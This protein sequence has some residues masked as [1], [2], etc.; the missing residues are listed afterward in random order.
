MYILPEKICVLAVDDDQEII[1]IISHYLTEDTRFS[2]IGATSVAQALEILVKEPISA[3]I[4]DYQMPGTDGIEFLSYLRDQGNDLP[5]ILFTGRGCEEVVI[6]ALNHGANFYLMKGEQPALQFQM[7]KKQLIEIIAKREADKAL[8]RSVSKNRRM[9]A[10]LRATLEAT[11]DG[12]LVAGEDGI[13]TDYNDRFVQIWNIPESDRENLTINRFI[14]FLSSQVKDNPLALF[15]PVDA[16][17]TIFSSSHYSLTTLDERII[18]LYIHPQ[19]CDSKAIGRVFSF[20]DITSRVKTERLLHESRERFRN[21]FEFSPIS[22]QVLDTD[23]IIREVNLAWLKMMHLSRE[24]VLGTPFINLIEPTLRERFVACIEDILQNGKKHCVELT[25]LDGEGRQVLVLADGNVIRDNQGRIRQIQ[26]ILRDITYQKKTEKQLKW[27]ESLLTEIVGMLPFGICVTQGNGYDIQYQNSRFADLWG[28]DTVSE[29]S[30]ERDTISL[31]DFFNVS[32]YQFLTLSQYWDRDA[33]VGSEIS[34]SDIELHDRKIIRAFKRRIGED[35]HE[36]QTLWA[37]EDVTRFRMQEEEIRRYARKIEIFSRVISIS[38][39]AKDLT[40]L[41]KYALSAL[42]SLLNVDGGGLYIKK[43]EKQEF[44]LFCHTGGKTGFFESKT[45]IDDSNEIFFKEPGRP[46]LVRRYHEVDPDGAERCDISSAAFIPIMHEDRVIGTIFLIGSNG[47]GIGE[48]DPETLL[49]IGREIGSAMIRLLDHERILEER[50]NFENLVNTIADM[51][52]VIDAVHG[53]ILAINTE[54]TRRTGLYAE[55]VIGRKLIERSSDDSTGTYQELVGEK[56]IYTHNF[57]GLSEE[58]IPVE[59][60]MTAGI[61]NG[62]EV[63]FCVS[64]DIREEKRASEEL[65]MREE[66]LVAIV[67][68]SPIGIA[69]FDGNDELIKVNPAAL[70]LIGVSGPEDVRHYSFSKDPHIPEEVKSLF[71]ARKPF[72]HEF[73]YNLSK[74]YDQKVFPTTRTGE[75]IIR[76]NVTPIHSQIQ[77]SRSSVLVLIEDIS[78]RYMIEKQ[79]RNLTRQLSQT[80]EASSD[81]FWIWDVASGTVTLSSKMK[82]MIGDTG[83]LDQYSITHIRNWVHPDDLSGLK[84]VFSQI[85][86]GAVNGISKEVRIIHPERGSFWIL[87]RG[88]VT[89]WDEE[90]RPLTVSGAVADIN[91][92]KLSEERLLESEEFNQSLISNLPDYLLIYDEEGKILFINDTA[93]SAMHLTAE[94]FIGRSILEFIFPGHHLMIKEKMEQRLRGEVIEPYEI[95]IVKKDGSIVDV[96]VQATRISYHGTPAILAVLTDISA[97]KRTETELARYADALKNTVDALASSNKKMNLLSNVTRHDILNQIHIVMS[98]LSL[99]ME[100]YPEPEV[101]KMYEKIARAVGNIHQHIEFTRNYQEIG[102]HSPVWQSPSACISKMDFRDIA[103]HMHLTGIELYADPLLPNVFENL[104]DNAI[105]HGE[106][107]QNITVDYEV[108]PDN[109]LLII[110]SDDGKGISKDDK[111]HIF[112][113]GYGKNTGLG[114]FLIREI[115]GLTGI[116]VY[117]T[118]VMG[119]GARFCIHVP[120]ERFR[121]SEVDR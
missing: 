108:Q 46:H 106:R 4:S 9:L 62:K 82:E 42:A 116:S 86:E 87:I 91:R 19:I 13:I 52:T 80:L 60:R 95:T 7:L 56:N 44:E 67:E 17:R 54:V 34:C 73:S 50:K 88:K 31:S 113:R 78:S 28:V 83:L 117:E 114:L 75:I 121:Y 104:L 81:G 26:C 119:E 100:S 85:K 58:T 105:R 69:L 76:I 32:D 79:V 49:G 2:V 118:G 16:A 65:R 6:K 115:L 96:E 99:L 36:D 10:Q 39:K 23:G 40:S 66:Q 15:E 90:G 11:E 89:D 53:T 102:V 72:S 38:G 37:F 43:R 109:T 18:E 71:A 41:C 27:T 107:V 45:I 47:K 33:C 1:D 8:K 64:R 77:D 84:L 61:W 70:Q 97:R 63:F 35:G 93:V 29:I 24:R 30:R 21:L 22:H 3:V 25:L 5:F 14:S 55:D 94:D 48:E 57:P 92:R 120:E 59:T 12:I 98:Y 74:A 101:E 103:L 111:D 20:R 51:V 110:W 68:S 112:E